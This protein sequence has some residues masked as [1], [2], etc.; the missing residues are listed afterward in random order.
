MK[1]IDNLKE[2]I[3]LNKNKPLTLNQDMSVYEASI[4][5]LETMASNYKTLVNELCYHCGK[6]RTEH[7]GSCKGC[8]WVEE[9]N[10]W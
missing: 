5:E 8:K 6:Y 7:L 1:S 10:K 3:A 9:K 4:N 2:F